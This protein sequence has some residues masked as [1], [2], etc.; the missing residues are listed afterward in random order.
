[1]STNQRW[2]TF[3]LLTI[4][5]ILGFIDLRL[6]SSLHQIPIQNTPSEKQGLL[7]PRVYTGLIKPQSYLIFN[8]NPLKDFLQSYIDRNNLNLSVYVVNLRDGGSLSINASKG[9]PPASLHKVPIA[10]LIAQD[11]EEGKLNWTTMLPINDAA[12][13]NSW[14]TLYKTTAHELPVRVLFEKMLQESDNTA[15]FTLG[16]YVKKEDYDRLVSDYLG[17]VLKDEKSNEKDPLI[18]PR[19]MYN[20]FS[21]LYFSTILLPDN[22]EYILSLLTNTT[23]DINAFANIPREVIIA[24]K[25]GDNY[26][27]GLQTFN[28]CGIMYIQDMRTFYCI[29]S[30]GIPQEKAAST[31]G[32]IVRQIYEFTIQAREHFDTQYVNS[33]D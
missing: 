13:S 26:E 16:D 8:Y 4:I 3:T 10:I 20:V 33:T 22:S 11:V 17:Y 15:F 28:D 2:L 29:M 6:N 1:M 23:F 14:G 32:Y 12:R 5:I 21:S 9:Y 25:F 31:I 30:S 7:S 18:S 24:Q 27:H 19:S